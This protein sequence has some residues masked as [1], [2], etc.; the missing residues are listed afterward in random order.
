MP[1]KLE[2]DTG[3]YRELQFTTAKPCKQKPVWKLLVG[4]KFYT[5]IDKLLVKE[6]E[7]VENKL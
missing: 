1:L 3:Q 2:R 5:V 4:R 7:L 6:L